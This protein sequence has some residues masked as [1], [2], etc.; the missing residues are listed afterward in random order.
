MTG[1]RNTL[2]P[3]PLFLNVSMGASATSEP[4]DVTYLDNLCLTLDWTGTPTGTFAVEICQT[5][6]GTYKALA[7][8]GSVAAAGAADDAQILLNQLEAPW[9][10]VVYTRTS[11]TGVLNGSL[12]GKQV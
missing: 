11:G 2:P 3:W 9:M 1:R 10:R 5:K 4:T 8:S 12:S 6:L 7:L